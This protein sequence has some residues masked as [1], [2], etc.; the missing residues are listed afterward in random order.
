M[1]I[2]YINITTLKGSVYL[3]HDCAND[4]YKIGATKS[5]VGKRLK[6]LQTGNATELTLR[7][8]HD[9]DYPFRVEKMLHNYFKN[10][11]VLNEW[12]DLSLEDV[13]GFKSTCAEME[14]RI[15]IL[16]ENPFFSKDLR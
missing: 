15:E 4:L 3:I 16:K 13:A 12:F 11:N 10:K 7:A 9:T 8:H 2:Q 1:F 5:D 14:E 6:K